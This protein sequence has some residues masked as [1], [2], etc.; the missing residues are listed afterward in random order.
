MYVYVYVYVRLQTSVKR[1]L[2][3]PVSSNTVRLQEPKTLNCLYIRKKQKPRRRYDVSPLR[4][5]IPR[6]KQEI[7]TE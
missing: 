1:E 4:V 7:T 6:I 5:R 2:E 3:L